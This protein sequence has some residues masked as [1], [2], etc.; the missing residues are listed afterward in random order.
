MAQQAAGPALFAANTRTIRLSSVQ[1]NAADVQALVLQ[2]FEE[3]RHKADAAAT[4]SA[5]ADGGGAPA[6]TLA[7]LLAESE[8][9]VDGEHEET[10]LLRMTALARQSMPASQQT[11]PTSQQTCVCE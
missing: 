9:A 2:E 11:M 5:E 6:P 7:D 8:K 3:R 1:V 10:R 4:G